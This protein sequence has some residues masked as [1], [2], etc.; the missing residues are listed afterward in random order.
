MDFIISSILLGV[1]LAMDAFT[2]SLANGLHDPKMKA[3][4]QLKIAGTFSVF[5]FLMPLIG[6]V[7]VHTIIE[8]FTSLQPL[9]PW[10][11]FGI[12]L[13]IGGKMIIEGWKEDHEKDKE[14]EEEEEEKDKSL[15]NRL[16]IVQGIATSIDA[17]SVGFA[18]ADY[19]MV[20]AL[21]A[22]GVIGV[23]TLFICLA[24]IK[25]GRK[26]GMLFAGKAS[27]MGGLVL[28]GIGVSL[29]IRG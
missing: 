15:G 23:V 5:Q 28:I 9:I 6:W 20:K 7:C 25:I 16:L 24:G 13:F 12:L 17:L 26:F 14:N 8:L 29:I 18:I 22:S 19:T 2:V 3:P 4:R 27:I 10:I 11:G 21:I 1:G